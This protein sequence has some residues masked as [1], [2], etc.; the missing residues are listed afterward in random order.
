MYVILA[1]LLCAFYGFYIGKKKPLKL[2]Q[3]KDLSKLN[4]NPKYY[5]Y[6]IFLW[7]LIPALITF[8][9]LNFFSNFLIKQIVID[10]V[11][12]IETVSKANIEF[13]YNQIKIMASGKADAF[14]TDEKLILASE[15][16]N[17]LNNIHNASVFLICTCLS[18]ILLIFFQKKINIEFPARKKVEKF[19]KFFLL[20]CSIVAVLTTVGIVLSL[21]FESLRFF[22]Q[23]TFDVK[24]FYAFRKRP[25]YRTCMNK[26]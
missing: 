10:L 14:N 20:I 13:I 21:F 2:I 25:I 16:Y 7:C 17:E 4:S 1:I 8:F 12:E 26:Q 22:K 18:A 6:Y 11:P 5:G 24:V 3:D 15:K 19:I 9:T 23:I